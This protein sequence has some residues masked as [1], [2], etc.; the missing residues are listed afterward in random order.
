[1]KEFWD[2]LFEIFTD[3]QPI[4]LVIKGLEGTY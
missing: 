1:M 2:H 4:L 3:R